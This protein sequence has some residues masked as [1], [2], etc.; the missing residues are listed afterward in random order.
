MEK[1]MLTKTPQQL[2]RSVN[3]SI[4]RELVAEAKALNVNLSRAA[5]QGL[6]DA[7]RKRK[8]ELWL[9]EHAEAIEANNRFF[10]ETGL[11][12]AEYRGF[13]DAEV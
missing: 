12:F 1:P 13:P 9:A 10:E 7:I 6:A 2:R 8:A 3:L 4:D 5:D 11:P